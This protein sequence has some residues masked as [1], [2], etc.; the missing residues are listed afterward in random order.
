MNQNENLTDGSLTSGTHISYWIDSI[1]PLSYGPIMRDISTD[2]V[3]VGAGISGLSVA[4]CAALAGK[5]VTVIDDG[6]VA[7]GETGRTTAHLSNAL[8]DRY[9]EIERIFGEEGSKLAAES[10]TMA[11]NFIEKVCKD[12]NIDCDFKRVSG[13]LFL[14][15]TDEEASIEKEFD[16]ATKAGIPVKK[17]TSVPYLKNDNSI[18]IEFPDQGQFHPGKYMLGLARAIVSK[19]GVIFNETHAQEIDESGVVTE[20]GYKINAKHVV[21][22]TNSPVNNKYIMHMKQFPYRTYVIG[23]TIRKGSVPFSLWWDTGDHKTNKDVP[24]YH[25]VRLQEYNDQ[26]DLIIVGG[27]DHPTGL[28]EVQTGSA[29]QAYKRLEDWTRERFDINEVVYHWSGQVLEPMDAMGFIGRNPMDKDNIYIVTGDSGNGMT[30]G[31]IAGLLISDLI[32]GRENPW[33][34]IYR[35]NRTNFLKSGKTFLGEFFR[36]LVQ[37]LK[38]S[39][40]DVK[41]RHLSNIPPGDAIIIKLD[42]EK[43]G[44]Y[45]DQ[46]GQLHLVS[47]TCTHLGCTVRWNRD[48]KSWDCPCHGSRFAYDGKVLNGPAK[49]NLLYYKDEPVTT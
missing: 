19:G 42:D 8:D 29:R 1:K 31:T 46:E 15:P 47:A 16:A 48:E 22:A 18:C 20:S 21:V 28:P 4:Y 23:A 34:K 39:S 17:L 43:Y 38:L 27:E 3:V 35:P 14:D 5:S 41:D 30:H 26:Y 13:Y 9:Y 32:N 7:S 6:A 45:R 10:H 2:V 36:G 25:Y 33:E 40:K 37:Y 12:E 11:I 49:E 44:A 24:P